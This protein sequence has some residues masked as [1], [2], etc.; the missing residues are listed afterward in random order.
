MV[1]AV[2][3]MDQHPV[4]LDGATL[5]SD[6]DSPKIATSI[7]ANFIVVDLSINMGFAQKYPLAISIGMR[8]RGKP[9][10]QAEQYY[11]TSSLLHPRILR[12]N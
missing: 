1:G 3:E 5:D 4:E 11:R 8:R 10:Q 9:Q 6:L 2:L 7:D 12:C